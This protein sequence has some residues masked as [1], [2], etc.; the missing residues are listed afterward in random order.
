M[1]SMKRRDRAKVKVFFK[2]SRMAEGELPPLRLQIIV[3]DMPADYKASLFSLVSS[4]ASEKNLQLARD[5]LAI[6]FG[7]YTK[8]PDGNVHEFLTDV[9]ERMEREVTGHDDAKRELMSMLTQWRIGGEFPFAIGLEG[10]PGIGKTTLVTRALASAMNRPVKVI[11]L[12]GASDAS[13]FVGHGF[14][15]ENARYGRLVEALMEAKCMDAILFFEELDKV[16]D[17]PRGAEIINILIHL[18]DPAQPTLRDRYFQGLD[19]DFSKCIKIFSY[20]DPE[21]VHPVLRDRLK[22]ITMD[23]PDSSTRKDIAMRHLIPR[24]KQQT[25]CDVPLDDVALDRAIDAHRDDVGMRGLERSLHNIFTNAVMCREYGSKSIVGLKD[26]PMSV[27]DAPFVTHVLAQRRDTS[28]SSVS[29]SLM[30][31]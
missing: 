11:C 14:T 7:R 17:S 8:P 4:N 21:R 16:S 20:N 29:A 9:R 10:Q 1:Q 2:S 3:S 22:R 6:P 19:L 5:A 26:A 13:T 24:L 30:Y 27:V 25:Q 31:Q 18:T 28:S 15:Y 23:V 12:G